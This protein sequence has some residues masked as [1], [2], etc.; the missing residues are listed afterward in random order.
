M[1]I[2]ILPPGVNVFPALGPLIRED[3]K[4]E[5]SG[6]LKSRSRRAATPDLHHESLDIYANC[7]G[8]LTLD[9]ATFVRTKGMIQIAFNRNAILE[10]FGFDSDELVA[11]RQGV[12]QEHSQALHSPGYERACARLR[13]GTRLTVADASYLVES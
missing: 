2:G 10:H 4:L 11:Y 1:L 7:C 8:L 9:A 13:P 12:L 6:K 3:I 5:S